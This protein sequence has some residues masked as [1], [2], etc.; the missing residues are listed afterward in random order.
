[1][2]LIPPQITVLESSRHST[3]K[4]KRRPQPPLSYIQLFW[5]IAFVFGSVPIQHKKQPAYN[6]GTACN[7]N[8]YTPKY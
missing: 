8:N 2:Y 5:L 1:M 4:K 6:P 7:T 3:M